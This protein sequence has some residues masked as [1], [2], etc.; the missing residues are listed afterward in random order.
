MPTESRVEAHTTA[1]VW[2]GMAVLAWVSNLYTLAIPWHKWYEGLK[3]IPLLRMRNAVYMVVWPM[4]YGLWATASYVAFSELRGK[5]VAL[6]VS[7]ECVSVIT[8]IVTSTWPF[9]FF[10]ARMIR[11]ALVVLIL[12]FL[13]TLAL[14]VM[15]FFLHIPSGGV[16]IPQCIWL[17]FALAMNCY[18][19]LFN[20]VD[21]N[22]SLVRAASTEEPD[23]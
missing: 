10:G 21:N 6:Y 14:T 15:F 16:M 3:H 17:A 13:L 4:I 19:V 1:A 18:V 12:A 11:L 2:F 22:A 23:L 20:D 9:L 7:T 5:S 8:L